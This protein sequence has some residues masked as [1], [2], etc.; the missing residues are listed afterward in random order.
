MTYL[1]K[2]GRF[3]TLPYIKFL[4]FSV[5]YLAFIVI[6]IA[7]DF[8]YAAVESESEKLSVSFSQYYENYVSYAEN[9]NL[10]YRFPATDMYFRRDMPHYIDIVIC[11]WVFGLN[12]R[13]TK[14]LFIYGIK[15]YMSSWN[16]ILVSIM[17]L[18]FFF[19]YALKYYTIVILRLEKAKLSDPSFWSTVGN[20][21]NNLE[22]QKDVYQTF[23]WLNEGFFFIGNSFLKTFTKIYALFEDRF[24]WF[25]LDPM[26]LSEVLS[27]LAI[28]LTFAR[29]CFWIPVNQNLGPLQITL[30]AMISVYLEKK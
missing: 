21:N 3:L 12:L 11:I 14:K 26:N 27:A 16:N 6:L 4:S 30:G 5:S 17:H 9:K 2:V 8:Q 23:Y 18:L 29:L 15:D 20:M 10:T 1:K 28:I 19:A 13:E 7:S 24:Y 22:A 25:A